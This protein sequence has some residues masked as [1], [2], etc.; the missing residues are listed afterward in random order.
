MKGKVVLVIVLVL[1]SVFQLL[2]YFYRLRLRRL[3]FDDRQRRNDT[4]T[5][6]TAH[7]LHTNATKSHLFATSAAADAVPSNPDDVRSPEIATSC[8]TLALP[9]KPLDPGVPPPCRDAHG[10]AHSPAFCKSNEKTFL[11]IVV[12]STASNFERR[13]L[14]RNRWLR[15][16]FKMKS[17]FT[18]R[19]SWKYL[20]LLGKPNAETKEKNEI[21]QKNIDAESCHFSDILQVDVMEDYYNLTAKKMAAFDYILQNHMDF[22]IL[23]KTDDDCF[24]NVQLT[25]EWLDDVTPNAYTCTRNALQHKGISSMGKYFFGGKCMLRISPD[26]NPQSKWYLSVNDYPSSHYPPVCFGPG[27]F[28]SYDLIKAISTIDG[29]EMRS[30]RLEDVHTAILLRRLGL[31]PEEC[32]SM[33]NRVVNYDRGCVDG[34]FPFIVM[35]SS[36]SRLLYLFNS[37]MEHSTCR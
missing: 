4:A 20:F 35:G 16:R 7:I 1:F 22:E 12:M 34:K 32:V 24:I 18:S 6:G 30:F 13:H 36:S 14:A 8:P 19:H 37:F 25:L 23:L 11:L 27:Y 5:K 26:R 28:L 17:D 33:T 9:L 21:L 2:N 15:S 29:D 31:M 3:S 10:F